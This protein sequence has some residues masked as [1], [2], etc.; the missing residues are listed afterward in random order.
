MFFFDDMTNK[1]GFS[2]GEEAPA[3]ADEVRKFYIGILNRYAEQNQ[4]N[5][6]AQATYDDG[7]N[8]CMIMAIPSEEV[9]DAYEPRGYNH[10]DQ[11]Q[12]KSVYAVMGDEIG[13]MEDNENLVE[14][15]ANIITVQVNFDEKAFESYLARL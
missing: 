15:M 6:R 5:Y 11:F 1:Y 4:N 13:K 12:W 10:N 3:E 7:N 8:E 14:D 9:I 2:G